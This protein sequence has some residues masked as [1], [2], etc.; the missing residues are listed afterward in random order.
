[1]D[2]G[3]L[4]VDGLNMGVFEAQT[5]HPYRPAE[6]ALENPEHD[7]LPNASGTYVDTQLRRNP[8]AMAPAK[9]RGIWFGALVTLSSKTFIDVQ[10]DKW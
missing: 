6:S 8:L 7:K 4:I 5:W 3:S 9:L 1:M 10:V 2:V